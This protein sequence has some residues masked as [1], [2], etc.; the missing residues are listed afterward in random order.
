MSHH[1][2]LLEEILNESGLWVSQKNPTTTISII[3]LPPAD[4]LPQ[5]PR[6]FDFLASNVIPLNITDLPNQPRPSLSTSLSRIT[7]PRSH[8]SGSFSWGDRSNNNEFKTLNGKII[9]SI[10]HIHND[11][12]LYNQDDFVSHILLYLGTNSSIVMPR[13]AVMMT[14]TRVTHLNDNNDN[15]KSPMLKRRRSSIK[16]SSSSF[17]GKHPIPMTTMNRKG[18]GGAGGRGDMSSRRGGGGEDV[19]LYNYN[20]SSSSTFSLSLLYLF[21]KEALNTSI[22]QFCDITLLDDNIASIHNRMKDLLDTTFATLDQSRHNN[23]NLNDLPDE[24]EIYDQLESY[25]QEETYDVVF[26][27]MTQLLRSMDIEVSRV[28]ESMIHLDFIQVGLKAKECQRVKKAVDALRQIGSV[29]TPADKLACLMM[30]ITILSEDEVDTDSLMSLLVLTLI[31]SQLPQLIASITYIKEFTFQKD[32][33][34]GQH[35]FALSTLDAALQYILESRA[36]LSAISARNH[37][38]WTSLREGKPDIDHLPQTTPKGN[39]D[40]NA[41]IHEDDDLKSLAQVRDRHG[42]NALLIAAAAGQATSVD[43]LLDRLGPS[44]HNDMNDSGETPLMLAVK[45][46]SID[47]VQILLAKDPFTQ[48]KAI[49]SKNRQGDSAFLLACALDKEENENEQQQRILDILLFSRKNQWNKN[50]LGQGPLHLAAMANNTKI[51][52]YLMDHLSSSFGA[53]D[54][55]VFQ[56]QNNQGET[57]LHQC[58]DPKVLEKY[59]NG[60]DQRQKANCSVLDIRDRQGRTPLLA[61]SAKAR[62]HMLDAYIQYINRNNN[63]PITVP[64]K[65]KERIYDYDTNGRTCLHLLAMY[66]GP[67]P[68]S[69]KPL[70]D[71]NGDDGTMIQPMKHEQDN[72]DI[73]QNIMR[74]F[75][76]LANVRDSIEGNTPFH[77]AV[78]N[79]KRS[80]ASTSAFIQSLVFDAGAQMDV[81]NFRGARPSHVCQDPSIL[82]ILDD[83]ALQV[84]K[85]VDACDYKWV[86]TR[87][88][89]IDSNKKEVYY[90]IQSGPHPE[91]AS[92]SG[93]E[94]RTVKRPLEDFKLLRKDILHEFPE[95]FLPTLRHIFDPEK[96]LPL[97]YD[98]QPP[99]HVLEE[100]LGRLIRFMD[101]LYQ[102]PILRHHEL[103]RIF[104]R[105]PE[106]TREDIVHASL[107]RRHLMIEKI[108]DDYPSET[109]L[110]G[111]DDKEYFFTFAQ[112]TIEPLRDALLGVVKTSRSVTKCRQVLE[113]RMQEVAQRLQVSSTIT[114][115]TTTVAIKVCARTTCDTAFGTISMWEE[116]SHIIQNMHDITDGILTALQGPLYLLTQRHELRT[117]LEQQ[118]E[119]LRRAK[120]WNEVFSTQD[121]RRHIEQ[122]KDQVVKTLQKLAR[123]GSQIIQSHQMISDEMAHFQRVHPDELKNR[124]RRMVKRQ[125]EKEKL[126]LLW[127]EE[128][129]QRLATTSF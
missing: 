88:I 57:F 76:K 47:T 56:W 62:I 120:T 27:R 77:L 95:V 91:V 8:R 114:R 75:Q 118:R 36:D 6:T 107:A 20:S 73:L 9:S 15:N 80:V 109:D 61:W 38:F 92:S 101:Y 70:L 32:L 128:T 72:T 10:R 3:L 65:P 41:T 85:G 19:V 60:D 54:D 44:I 125:L 48:N 81:L 74:V 86:V 111:S 2:P 1:H 78:M 33:S 113:Q 96:I 103:I 28:L 29:R 4:T 116:F 83:I 18:E 39:D 64:T 94:T 69:K 50:R 90:I 115:T 17:S 58:Q 14:T 53:L 102:H 49:H 126:K 7:S 23:K 68:F 46:K 122:S 117:Q 97:V 51:V 82:A 43:Y 12:I 52:L 104:V 79:N 59:L 123:V 24:D 22:R 34:I 35:G 63:D 66:E 110:G 67:I 100:A 112:T 105:S 16:S 11:A 121:Q 37:A 40:E 71:D 5:P 45:S 98:P 99:M 21:D 87:A 89:T 30:T 25:I 108:C 124:I 42:N 119:S 106:L 129:K 13:D 55:D 127:L 84:K 26:F 93:I 31:R